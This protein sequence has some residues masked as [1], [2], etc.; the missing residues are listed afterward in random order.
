MKTSLKTF[1][2][3]KATIQNEQPKII[4]REE[5]LKLALKT[6]ILQYYTHNKRIE[7]KEILH[8]RI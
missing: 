7:R 6:E 2:Y 3:S 8:F 5:R 1:N 4:G